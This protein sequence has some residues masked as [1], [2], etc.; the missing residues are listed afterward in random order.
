MITP[1][2]G[3]F[4]SSLRSFY[5]ELSF[6]LRERRHY[7]EEKTPCRRLCVNPVSYALKM[8]PHCIQSGYYVN[9]MTD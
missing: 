8:N 5:D 1:F 6:H 2:L 9:Q 7:V 3:S 4:Q